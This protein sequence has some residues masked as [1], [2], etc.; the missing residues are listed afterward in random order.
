MA[1][2]SKPDPLNAFGLA[3]V[4]QDANW[5]VVA[6]TDFAGQVLEHNY[7]T[8]YGIV[9]VDQ[10]T[11]FGDYDGDGYVTL[12]EADTNSNGSFGTGDTC[13]GSGPSGA[14]R[15]Y[16]FDF[17]GDVD[18]DDATTLGTLTSSTTYRQPGRA[19]SGIGNTRAHQGL[20][21][22]VEIGSYNNRAR[23]YAPQLKRFMQMDAHGLRQRNGATDETGNLVFKER[24]LPRQH[25][26]EGLSL[27]A[28]VG[29]NPCAHRDASGES[30]TCYGTIQWDPG[31]TGGDPVIIPVEWTC[32]N[33]WRCKKFHYCGPMN[34]DYIECIPNDTGGY[35]CDY[36]VT[37][38]CYYNPDSFCLW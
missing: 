11:Y 15:V 38:A 35:D 31:P 30:H 26:P 2:I 22:D 25:Y 7:Y 27:Y 33:C 29:A 8:P 36:S 34:T 23:Q 18:S 24:V 3:F 28:Y 1:R 9:T 10:E 13:W 20:I 37:V 5:N 19:F 32:R 16:D 6:L 12:E 4:H 14:C 21:L 17:D